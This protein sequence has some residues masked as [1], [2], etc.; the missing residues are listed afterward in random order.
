MVEPNNDG[1]PITAPKSQGL[2]PSRNRVNYV[3]DQTEEVF[4]TEGTGDRIEFN[5]E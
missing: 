4:G 3:S 5:E 2:R 1:T